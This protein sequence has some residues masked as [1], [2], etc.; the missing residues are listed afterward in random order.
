[1]ATFVDRRF[2][3]GSQAIIGDFGET[4]YVRERIDGNGSISDAFS[5]IALS[6]AAVFRFQSM[7]RADVFTVAPLQMDIRSNKA[8]CPKVLLQPEVE[9]ALELQGIEVEGLERTQHRNDHRIQFVF[10]Q[11]SSKPVLKIACPRSLFQEDAIERLVFNLEQIVRVA[12]DRPDTL[13][14]DLPDLRDREAGLRP[15]DR[16]ERESSAFQP[17]FPL[18]FE[19]SPPMP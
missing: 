1:M 17:F 15:L 7:T 8:S 2:L 9:S 12:I 13:L 4:R 10:Q 5:V 18:G 16:E 3:E 6:V 14:R 11:W 19:P